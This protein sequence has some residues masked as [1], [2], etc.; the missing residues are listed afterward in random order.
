MSVARGEI[1][2]GVLPMSEI[3]P[4][5]GVAVLGTFPADV[6]SY[7]V[8]MAGVSLG[9][10]Q[11]TA[12]RDLIRF[13]TSPAAL[14]VI[15]KKGMERRGARYAET[16][17]RSSF[18][19]L[20]PGS[21]EPT[22]STR[23]AITCAVAMGC[24]S[25]TSRGCQKC[26]GG[27]QTR[28]RWVVHARRSGGFP[29]GAASGRHTESHAVGIGPGI[30]VARRWFTDRLPAG[31]AIACSAM[32]SCDVLSITCSVAISAGASPALARDSATSAS[33]GPGRNTYSRVSATGPVKPAGSASD[34]CHGAA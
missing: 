28:L 2:L 6:Q 18:F 1:E 10:S 19:V 30:V 8:N 5:A 4:V 3:L 24:A 16:A 21:C 13:L 20:V 31:I 12:A 23:S 14:P 9:G 7:L 25:G 22:S 17:L 33:S 29:F 34:W 11:G 26:S 15:K 27:S 32:T